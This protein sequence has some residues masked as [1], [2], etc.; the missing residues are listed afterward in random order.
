MQLTNDEKRAFQKLARRYLN[1]LTVQKMEQYIQHGDVDTLTHV[2]HVAETSFLLNR[3]LH[4]GAHEQALVSGALLHDFYLY[5]WHAE[6]GGSHKWHGFRSGS[7]SR[8]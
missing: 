4:L 3:R 8:R 5:D 2:K 1:D 6:D 7:G